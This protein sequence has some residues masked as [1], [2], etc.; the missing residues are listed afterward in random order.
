[1]HLLIAEDRPAIQLALLCLL[2]DCGW[3]ADFVS[4]GYEAVVHALTRQ[5]D[6]ALLDLTMPVLDGIQ[7]CQNIREYSSYYLPIMAISAN[8]WEAERCLAAGMDEFLAKPWDIYDLQAKIKSLTVKAGMIER[9]GNYLLFKKEKPMNAKHLQELR[10]LDEKGLTKLIVKAAGGELVVHKNAQNKIAHDFV[11]ENKEIS[12]FLDRSDDKPGLCHLYRCSLN[13]KC[14]LP[15]VLDKLA[16]AE[17][18]QME[19]F[20]QAILKRE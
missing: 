20:G 13:V 2:T 19:A 14:L 15:E 17:D 12:E 1:M 10:N 4:N 11:N 3:S 8:T 6:L 9:C 7:A 18:K 16:A 5:Y